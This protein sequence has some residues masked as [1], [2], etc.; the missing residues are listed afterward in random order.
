VTAGVGSLLVPAS[1]FV[2]TLSLVVVAQCYRGYVRNGSR[3]LLFLGLGVALVTLPSLLLYSVAV[4]FA[5]PAYVDLV[6][7]AQLLGLLSLLYAFTRA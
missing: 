2:A 3:P 5:V 4:A 7:L 6:V 1:L